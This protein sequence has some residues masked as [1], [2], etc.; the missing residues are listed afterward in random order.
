MALKISEKDGV[1]TF[2]VRVA[3][4]GRRNEIIGEHGDGI[5]IRLQAPPVEGKANEA[6]REF[7]AGQLGVSNRDIEII[8]GHT[9]RWKR[10]EV[11]G[12]G[13]DAIEALLVGS[14]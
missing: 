5:K 10:V 1:C 2:R 7:L 8:S 12:V 11:G 13:A 3:P 9:S 4:R 14:R 6:L